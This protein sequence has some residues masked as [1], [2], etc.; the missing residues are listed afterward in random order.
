MSGNLLRP[1]EYQLKQFT[2]LPRGDEEGAR[3]DV[4]GILSDKVRRF[5]CILGNVFSP[6]V[7]LLGVKSELASLTLT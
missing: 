2:L 6:L 5:L 1:R 3:Q 4:R 7:S